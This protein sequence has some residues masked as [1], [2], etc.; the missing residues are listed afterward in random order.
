LLQSFPEHLTLRKTK[1]MT[2]KIP[3]KTPLDSYI[4]NSFADWDKIPDRVQKKHGIQTLMKAADNKTKHKTRLLR[5][6]IEASPSTTPNPHVP[7]H[8]NYSNSKRKANKE[9]TT[10]AAWILQ[11]PKTNTLGA[12]APG[13]KVRRS[14]PGDTGTMRASCSGIRRGRNPVARTM[15]VAAAAAAPVLLP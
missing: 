9:Q 4:Y 1:K 13:G 7:L 3:S 10:T 8:K 14:S 5:N 11:H 15:P 6:L 2:S 12:A